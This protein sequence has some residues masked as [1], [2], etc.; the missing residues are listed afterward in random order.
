MEKEA[1]GRFS[2]LVMSP[3]RTVV[4]LFVR[5]NG[6]LTKIGEKEFRV[7]LVPDPEVVIGKEVSGATF[8]KAVLAAQLGVR[9][10][11][12]NFDYDVKFQVES[13]T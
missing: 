1:P 11:L 5:E 8:K 6:N 7:K 2:V 12:D 4:E 3:G 9:A 13:F 10:V